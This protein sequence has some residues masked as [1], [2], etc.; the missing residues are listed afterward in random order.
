M[1]APTNVFILLGEIAD[2]VYAELERQGVR[3]HVVAQPLPLSRNHPPVATVETTGHGT[4][5]ISA[6][7]TANTPRGAVLSSEDA[8]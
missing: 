8:K 5:P 1:S 7:D 6:P 4:A 2:A 3:I